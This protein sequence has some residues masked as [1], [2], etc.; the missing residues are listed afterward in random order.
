MLIGDVSNGDQVRYVTAQ[1]IADLSSAG[2]LS[3]PLVVGDGLDPA[4]LNFDG[5]STATVSVLASDS[6]ISIDS[7]GI[8]VEKVPNKVEFNDGLTG[9]DFD[10]SSQSSVSV[11]TSPSRGLQVTSN[12]VELDVA[13]LP[14]S[15]PTSADYMVFYDVALSEER[16]NTFGTFMNNIIQPAIDASRDLG[17][18]FSL[19]EG[20]GISAF[21]FNGSSAGET[22]SIDQSTVPMLAND[23][24]YT[25]K[26][27]FTE[28]LSGSL[29]QLSDG[30]SYLVA[31]KFIQITSA[32]NGQVII[33][34]T[35][36]G[37]IVTG[38]ISDV[39]QGVP[40]VVTT[41]EDHNLN[42]NQGVTITEVVG[43]TELNG[44]KYYAD[45]LSYNTFALYTDMDLLFPLD[46]S[47]FNSYISDGEFVGEA[48]GNVKSDAPFITWNLDPDLTNERVITGSMGVS[49]ENNGVDK[50][51]LSTDPKKVSYDCTGSLPASY[52]LEVPG[53]AFSE[54]GKSWNKTDIYLNGQL[55]LSGTDKDYVLGDGD[56]DIIFYF[57]LV[58]HDSLLFKLN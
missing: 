53:I 41:V 11:A 7:S 16:K 48:G 39:T 27:V 19:T 2:I 45:V 43:M 18:P 56:S 5:S 8:S 28:G 31:G 51:I 15:Q 42:E 36:T 50:I 3:N 23:N 24:L 14:F 21:S 34:S 55:L 1:S 32:S 33:S 44:N 17:T 47:G 30:S 4:G 49:I 10:G 58:E 20:T 25:G 6:T 37:G 52:A 29:T 12:G 35:A 9:N 54:N 38:S 46:T 13:N 57:A 40:G 22:V 26:A